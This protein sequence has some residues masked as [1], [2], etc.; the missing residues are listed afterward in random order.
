MKEICWD[1]SIWRLDSTLYIRDA[2]GIINFSA[3]DIRDCEELKSIYPALNNWSNEALI[4][5]WG[6]YCSDYNLTSWTEPF[7]SYQFLPYLYLAQEGK[8]PDTSED[9]EAIH[10]FLISLA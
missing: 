1:S 3:E 9:P 4:S 10:D 2:Q 5:A 6:N 8:L 7:E